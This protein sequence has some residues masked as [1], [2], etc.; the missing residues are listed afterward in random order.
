M[1]AQAYGR[2]VERGYAA[3][4]TVLVGESGP[5]LHFL[6]P[7]TATARRGY[8]YWYR[9]PQEPPDDGPAGVPAKV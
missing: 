4:W 2:L 9:A 5:E 6:R 3:G 8:F 7:A 1:D